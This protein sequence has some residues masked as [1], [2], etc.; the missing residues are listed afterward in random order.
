MKIPHTQAVIPAV[1]PLL[2]KMRIRST[3]KTIAFTPEDMVGHSTDDRGFLCELCRR[4]HPLARRLVTACC[5]D[6]ISQR[7]VDVQ[8]PT[9]VSSI[10]A[11]AHLMPRVT[12]L[13]KFTPTPLRPEIRECQVIDREIDGDDA[14]ALN[15]ALNLFADVTL[16]G[17]S[18]WI[19]RRF[20]SQ[21]S[22][23]TL[24]Y[25]YTTGVYSPTAHMAIRHSGGRVRMLR[26]GQYRDLA[27]RKRLPREDRLL[28]FES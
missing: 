5:A 21:P 16:A 2:A 10:S 13:L 26:D 28:L 12:D 22:G 15:N 1:S 6:G 25:G 18:R 8:T 23:I 9:G 27:N 11:P 20:P 19:R 14:L 7:V 17:D 24:D 3:V 4:G